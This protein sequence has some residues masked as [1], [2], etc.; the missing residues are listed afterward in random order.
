MTDFAGSHAGD[1]RAEELLA[2]IGE[3]V[4]AYHDVELRL[5]A[6]ADAADLQTTLRR[7][8]PAGAPQPVVVP[9][10]VEALRRGA[11]SPLL[12]ERH[13]GSRPHRRPVDLERRYFGGMPPAAHLGAAEWFAASSGRPRTFVLD[14][15]VD[16][17]DVAS[18]A[19]DYC[20]TA[21]DVFLHGTAA[22]DAAD[23]ATWVGIGFAGLPSV[24]VVPVEETLLQV[25][26][27]NDGADVTLTARDEATRLLAIARE[28]AYED[29]WA[30]W[31]DEETLLGSQELD[32]AQARVEA[33]FREAM[34]ETPATGTATGTGRVP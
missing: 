20:F 18:F 15:S 24:L 3:G 16:G 26:V 25:L 21:D 6:F 13:R 22:P 27:D 28:D 1:V 7:V 32:E 11:S 10:D 31:L 29:R 34:L 8:I 17:A 9:V 14:V 4:V 30:R 12:F 2:R 33:E 5:S 23:A 19:A